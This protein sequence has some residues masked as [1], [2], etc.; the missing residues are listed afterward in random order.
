MINI[1]LI[2]LGTSLWEELTF[3]GLFQWITKKFTNKTWQIILPQSIIFA[4]LHALSGGFDIQVLYSFAFGYI[5]GY[6]V[7]RLGFK[8]GLPLVILMHFLINVAGLSYGVYVEG[9]DIETIIT[10]T[11]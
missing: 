9:L 7:R 4:L 8:K 5:F 10:R 6:I 2:S 3:R 1:L 11:Q